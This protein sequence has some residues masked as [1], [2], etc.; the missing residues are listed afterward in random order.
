MLGNVQGSAE[1]GRAGWEHICMRKT[2]CPALAGVWQPEQGR[3]KICGT[4]GSFTEIVTFFFL[5]S[6]FCVFVSAFV[7]IFLCVG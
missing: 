5:F 1:R 2:L 3:S 6:F 4:M 7:G